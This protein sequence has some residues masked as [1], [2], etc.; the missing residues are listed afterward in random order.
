MSRYHACQGETL[1]GSLRETAAEPE[2]AGKMGATQRRCGA[3]LTLRLSRLE[4]AAECKRAGEMRKVYLPKLGR[5]FT[6]VRLTPRQNRHS[7]SAANGLQNVRSFFPLHSPCFFLLPLILAH[8]EF[9]I[10]PGWNANGQLWGPMQTAIMVV[11]CW[12]SVNIAA[13]V[14]WTWYCLRLARPDSWRL[15]PMRDVNR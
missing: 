14:N 3:L 12:L 4:A 8:L 15:E 9:W 10:V 13:A 5:E 7:S 2:N 11:T 6:G 1:L